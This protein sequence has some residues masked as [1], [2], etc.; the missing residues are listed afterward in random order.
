MKR[1][2]TLIE[3][4]VVIA[5]IA[6]LA[7]ILFPVF[8]Q[9]KAAAKK[10][11]AVSN[12]KQYG[13]SINIYLADSDD[14]LPSAFGQREPGTD[15]YMSGVATPYPPNAL[16]TAPWNT[17][18]RRAQAANMIANSV[19]PYMKNLQLQEVPTA[20]AGTITTETPNPGATV[21]NSGMAYNGFLHSMSTSAVANGSVVPLVW[22]GFG[23][24]MLKYRAAIQ[25][26][27]TCS[28]A[29]PNG[30]VPCQFNPTGYPQTNGTGPFGWVGI[31]PS[32]TKAATFGNRGIVCRVDS[33]TKAL[34]VGV[35]QGD[36]NVAPPA[37]TLQSAYGD[38]FAKVGP[39]GD[40]TQGA[41]ITSCTLGGGPGYWCYFR[42]DRDQ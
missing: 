5:I 16:N 2:F 41:Y 29:S 37:A 15:T 33:S 22:T 7:A 42:P 23:N 4:L 11:T 39:D 31:G 10:T 38:P 17:D 25:P 27:L 24:G 26:A 6:I 21:A 28:V 9:A 19:Q 36:L 18:F 14:M 30:S 35:L 32:Y 34:P 20:T 1:A 8:A 40:I 3:L 12:A 13:T